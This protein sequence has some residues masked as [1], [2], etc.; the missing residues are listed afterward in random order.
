MTFHLA[1]AKIILGALAQ[2]DRIESNQLTLL[3]EM[4]TFKDTIIAA[5]NFAKA[6]IKQLELENE[7]LA[8]DDADDAADLAAAREETAAAKAE[9]ERT[10]ATDTAE[11]NEI[12]AAAA[13][14][15][16]VVEEPPVEEVPV[17]EVP[18]EEPPVEEVPTE[19]QG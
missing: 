3:S 15:I 17:E 10:I 9:L 12:L 5:F 1:D 19:G 16:P 18:V 7:A 6:R 11:D 8:A 2:L 4:A 13:E 14:F